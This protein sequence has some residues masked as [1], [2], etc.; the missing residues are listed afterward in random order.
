MRTGAAKTQSAGAERKLVS[1]G[2]SEGDFTVWESLELTLGVGSKD[3]LIFVKEPLSLKCKA[4]FSVSVSVRM[5]D[6]ILA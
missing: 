1:C 2:L 3:I 4:L 6:S 5:A